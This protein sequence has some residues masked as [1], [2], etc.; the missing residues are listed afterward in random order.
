MSA[1]VRS[2]TARDEDRDSLVL[3][4]LNAVHDNSRVTQRTVAHELGIALG[5]ANAYMKRCA[6]KGLIKIGQAPA[7]RYA[8]YLTPKGFSEKSRLTAKYLGASLTFFRR[9]RN[10]CTDLLLRQCSAG[11]RQ[12]VGL[13][14]LSDL[15]DVVV[16][17]ARDLPV[18]IVGIIAPGA[19]SNNYQGLPVVPDLNALAPLDIVIVT[20]LTAPQATFDRM[21]GLLGN[22]VVA[23]PLLKL[24]P[25]AAPAA[26]EGEPL[27]A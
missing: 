3:G 6:R 18:D 11:G 1:D 2:A 12:R 15:V 9:A 10:E 17:C 27:R 14:G 26:V 16:L 19:E 23:P 20:D 5:L 4:I 21:T 22:R 7:R 8:Y 25:R 13:A 24:A